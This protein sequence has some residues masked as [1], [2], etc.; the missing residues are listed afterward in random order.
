MIALFTGAVDPAE[1]VSSALTGQMVSMNY[2]LGPPWSCSTSV[3]ANG[4]RPAR[5]YRSTI[6][7]DVV[8]GNA[9]HD[10]V[11]SGAYSED[12]YYGY[13]AKSKTYWTNNASNMGSHGYQTS[14]DGLSFREPLG[15]AHQI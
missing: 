9:L 11:S 15:W 6:A 14:V 8:P 5:T 1:A 4:S 10:H 13:D 12:A 2:L 7:F 3:P